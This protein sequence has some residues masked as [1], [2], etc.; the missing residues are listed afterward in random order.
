MRT[1]KYNSRG[2]ACLTARSLCCALWLRLGTEKKKLRSTWCVRQW[3][4]VH[5]TM[6]HAAQHKPG[7]LAFEMRE[8]IITIIVADLWV[9][10]PFGNGVSY[11]WCAHCNSNYDYH[12]IFLFVISPEGWWRIFHFILP[13]SI[14]MG[15]FL[16]SK[17]MKMKPKVTFNVCY[18]RLELRGHRM[19]NCLHHVELE[20]LW[21][22]W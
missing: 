5:S 3:F 15:F 18:C 16:S 20:L 22:L 19:R 8:Q 4:K 9:V 6:L 21:S 12:F 7:Y 17:I 14:D 1:S 13:S 2:L 10:F 11:F